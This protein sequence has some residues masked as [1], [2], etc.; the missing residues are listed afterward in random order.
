[1]H[2]AMDQSML[3]ACGHDPSNAWN[4][5]DGVMRCVVCH[6]ETEP[7]IDAVLK[8]QART[9]DVEIDRI[10]SAADEMD[11]LYQASKPPDIIELKRVNG[12]LEAVVWLFG[13]KHELSE[14]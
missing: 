11:R 10:I 7:V 3:M 13:A 1:M 2:P 5:S 8:E 12:K 14:S 9:Y 4:Y 6:D